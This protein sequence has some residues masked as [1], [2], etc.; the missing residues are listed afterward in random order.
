MLVDSLPGALVS[1]EIS[2]SSVTGGSGSE[3]LTSGCAVSSPSRLFISSILGGMAVPV[4]LSEFGVSE[5]GV[6]GLGLMVISAACSPSGVEVILLTTTF[7]VEDVLGLLD[8]RA[9]EVVA[10]AEEILEETSLVKVSCSVGFSCS[11]LIVAKCDASM[12]E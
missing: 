1:S 12:A 11:L 3:E 9:L 6:V 8:T 4:L 10:A 5:S 2:V 7:T